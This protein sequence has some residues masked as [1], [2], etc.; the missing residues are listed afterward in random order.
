MHQVVKD[1]KNDIDKD[2][3]G[4]KDAKWTGS[5]GTTG[6]PNNYD[7]KNTLFEIR[8][9]L[10]DETIV[11]NKPQEVYVGTDTRD[12]YHAGW[13]V[14]TEVINPRDSERF[15]Q[16]TREP[17]M[18]KTK[19]TSEKL[20]MGQMNRTGVAYATPEQ[21][22]GE[23]SRKVAREKEDTQDLRKELTAKVQYEMPRASQ[24]AVNGIVTRMINNKLH[25]A[26]IAD[27]PEL[28]LKPN[29]DKTLRVQKVKERYHNGK[30][31]V[32][33]FCPK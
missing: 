32:N 7:H 6:H 21:L 15:L 3:L 24:E 33:R 25:D 22:S 26:E 28:T 29:C 23:I 4:A 5:V 1:V 27:D 10:K 17:V 30:Y 8:T 16:A 12:V 9:G 2:H 31:E 11:P 18:A 14:S 13:N 19:M 20:L